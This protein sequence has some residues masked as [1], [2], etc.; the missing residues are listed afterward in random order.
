[1]S[2]TDFWPLFFL[3]SPKLCLSSAARAV[4]FGGY[5]NAINVDARRLLLGATENCSEKPRVRVME[6]GLDACKRRPIGQRW[7]LFSG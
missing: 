5:V 2:G 7:T 3:Y 4:P 1:M 6:P